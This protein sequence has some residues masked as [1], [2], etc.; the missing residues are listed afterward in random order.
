MCALALQI[1]AAQQPAQL[2]DALPPPPPRELCP[3]TASVSMTSVTGAHVEP[4][5]TR[6]MCWLHPGLADGLSERP[7]E[8]GSP[9]PEVRSCKYLGGAL[10]CW[11]LPN[12]ADGLL[13]R[14]RGTRNL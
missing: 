1:A 3:Q 2:K 13:Q 11:L 5:R 7:P 10:V 8:A 9:S 4:R 6:M 14:P 12:F